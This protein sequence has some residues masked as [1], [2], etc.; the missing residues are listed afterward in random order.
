MQTFKNKIALCGLLVIMALTTANA[1]QKVV[2]F[3]NP[4]KPEYTVVLPQQ[5]QWKP[6][7]N[8]PKGAYVAILEG[9]PSNLGPFTIREKIPPHFKL[10]S[11]Y[12][13]TAEHVTVLSGVFYTNGGDHFTKIGGHRLTAGS[14]SVNPPKF[15]HFGWTE[16]QGAVIQINGVGPWTRTYLNPKMHLKNNNG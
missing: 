10:L 16:D 8:L 14:Y 15:H 7:P 9:N 13:T 5:I 1:A 3:Y 11:H 4:L 12:H 2:T 6:I